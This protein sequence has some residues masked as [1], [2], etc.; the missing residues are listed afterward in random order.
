MSLTEF[1]R[2]IRGFL[3]RCGL[4]QPKIGVLAIGSLAWDGDRRENWW[5]SRLRMDR[6]VAV[7]LPM[8]YGKSA[9][10]RNNTFTM[11]YGGGEGTALVIPCLRRCTRLEVLL[12]EAMEL[13]RAER[14][15]EA[16]PGE[17]HKSWGTVCAIFRSDALTGALSS[18]WSAH[19][20][21]IGPSSVPLVRDGI[22]TLGWPTTKRGEPVDFDVLLGTA[23]IPD[24][25]DLG[26]EAVARRWMTNKHE[27]YFFRNVEKGIQTS[28]DGAIWAEMC[29][30]PEWAA[31]MNQKYP[32]GTGILRGGLEAAALK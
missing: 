20:R 22:L 14:K 30:S 19:F 31:E 1:K 23:N 27:Y 16:Q 15:G 28:E 12:E 29:T 25:N 5:R 2:G 6:S 10:S 21:S 3:I 24:R 7:K 32:K 26:A 18:G 4:S 13:W 17:L 11:C 8:H 9:K